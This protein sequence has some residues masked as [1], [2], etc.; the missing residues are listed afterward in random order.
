MK[1]HPFETRCA[2]RLVRSE[3]SY[4]CPHN[5]IYF[6]QGSL[7]RGRQ[8]VLLLIVVTSRLSLTRTRRLSS[9]A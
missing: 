4:G 3:K 7:H 1:R 5:P 2:L 6:H 8:G 9:G